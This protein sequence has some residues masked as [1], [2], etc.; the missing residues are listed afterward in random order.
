[1]TTEKLC[2]KWND[3][4]DMIQAS[5]EELRGDNDFTDVTLACEDQSIKAHK[6]ILS[7]CSP[8]FRKLLKTHSHPHPLIYMRGMKSNDL[9]AMV[10]FIYLGEASMF[11]EQ[12][13]SFL[14]LAEELQLRGLDGSSEE[15]SEEHPNESF[16]HDERRADLN[17]KLNT[18]EGV[19]SNVK[20]ESKIFGGEMVP[21]QRKAKLN[22]II[23]PD[24]LAH[25]QSMIEKQINGFLCTNCGHKSNNIGHMKEHV[26]KHIKGL[27]Y[28]CN[29]CNKVYRSS[30]S[31]RM[32]NCSSIYR[33]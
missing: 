26:E 19:V 27:E 6:V 33:N 28:L 16:T 11:Q 24:T 17:Q 29:L 4:Q 32:H 31:L 18:N 7:A 21:L 22:S 10:D 30:A 20:Y 14:A 3:F 15:K 13:E 1:M 12:L 9:T 8:F 5:F 25:I 23:E 2:L